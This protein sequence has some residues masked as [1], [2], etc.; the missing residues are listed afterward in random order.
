MAAY[1]R[2]CNPV[3]VPYMA[4]CLIRRTGLLDMNLRGGLLLSR[5]FTT[6]NTAEETTRMPR[7]ASIG[8]LMFTFSKGMSYRHQ[9]R[10]L[11]YFFGRKMRTSV[12]ARASCT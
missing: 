9:M 3:R 5:N 10:K 8:N 4:D 2:L 6:V 1:A 11:G 12:S 7:P